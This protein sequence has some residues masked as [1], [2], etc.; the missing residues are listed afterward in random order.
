MIRRYYL[1][2]FV[3]TSIEEYNLFLN[4]VFNDTSAG[5]FLTWLEKFAVNR[6]NDLLKFFIISINS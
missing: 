5:R 1:Y 2:T 4:K 3:H 6:Q